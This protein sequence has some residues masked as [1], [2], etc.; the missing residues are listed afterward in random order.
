MTGR[1]PFVRSEGIA[2]RQAHA[3]LPEGTYEREVGRDGFYGPATHF[4]HRHAPTGWSH[5]E[6]PLAPHAFDTRRLETPQASPWMAAELFFN[7]QVRYRMWCLDESMPNLARNA[8]GDELLF[9]H[10]GRAELYCDYGHLSLCE[11]DYLV[12]P[13]GTMWRLEVEALLE[14]LLIEATGSRYALPDRGLLGAHAL[15]DPGVFDLPEMDEAFRVQQDER[16]TVVEV[17]ARGEITRITYPWNPLDALGWK[18]DLA[19]VRLNWRDIRPISAERYHLPPSAHATFEAE[20]FVVCT[21]CPRPLEQDP[22][23]LRLPFFHSNEDFDEVLFYHA[24]QFMSRDDLA[25]GAITWHPAGFPHGPHPKAL[26]AAMEGSRSR[27][28]EVA[29]MLD[30]RRPLELGDAAAAIETPGYVDSWRTS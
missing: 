11:G 7:E 17:K 28:D 20:G 21:F 23:A 13:R 19:P 10:S 5:F 3:D 29:V 18:G 9:I 16:E 24:G 6:G 14:V 22:D 4:Y 1:I 27:T 2:S 8:D 12:L 25:A 30:T 15:F 26:K